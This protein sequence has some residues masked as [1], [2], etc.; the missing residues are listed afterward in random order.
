MAG[1]TS[2]AAKR[3]DNRLKRDRERAEAA[4]LHARGVQDWVPVD[5][6]FSDPRYQRPLDQRHIDRMAAEFNPDA[7]GVIYVSDRGNGTIAVMDGFHRVAVMRQLGWD[8]QKMPALVFTGLSVQEEAEIFTAM[9]K[10][11]RQPSRIHLFRAQVAAGDKHAVALNEVLVECGVK[12]IAGPAPRHLQAVGAVQ[13]VIEIAGADIVRRAVKIATT[14]WSQHDDALAGPLLSG[15]ALLIYAEADI[16]DKAM[17]RRLEDH[18]PGMI[19]NKAKVTKE[20]NPDLHQPAAVATVL[21]TLYNQRRRTGR[22]PSFEYRGWPKRSPTG[23]LH[24]NGWTE[25]RTALDDDDQD[26]D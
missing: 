20:V 5:A 15:L 22:L 25:D 21:T 9:N 12:V 10:D 23:L 14:A 24:G 19:M 18:T 3:R 8:D 13:K 7:L 1:N 26:D 2:G 17:I 4:G 6:L 11:R 16:D